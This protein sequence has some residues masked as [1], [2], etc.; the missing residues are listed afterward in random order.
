MPE[1]TQSQNAGIAEFD[2]YA[3][4]ENYQAA[5]DSG[6]KLSGENSAYFARERINHLGG[7]LNERGLIPNSGLQ[8]IL[9]FG[10]GNGGSIGLLQEAFKPVRG[11]TGADVSP[12]GLE[13]ARQRHPG[14]PYQF[15]PT[16][17]LVNH[18]AA[19]DLA[20]CN[21]VFHHIPLAEREDALAL[22]H[23]ALRPGGV[24][25]FWENNPLNPLVLYA[26]KKV[27]FDADAITIVPALARALLREAGFKILDTHFLFFFPNTL[28]SLRGLEPAL[29]RVPLG[30]QYLVLAR[31]PA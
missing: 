5:L 26:M 6:L 30:G 23:Q 20:F 14:D 18:P 28:A 15:L 13:V 10:C 7:I 31:K 17:Q 19:F 25:A 1:P 21:G 9:D 4:P 22:V 2:A 8:K 3:D 11:V 27:P 29:R 16:H 12:A 24:F